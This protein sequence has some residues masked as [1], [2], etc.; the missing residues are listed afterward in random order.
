[1]KII[2]I[3]K[4]IIIIIIKKIKI[5]IMFIYQVSDLYELS[6]SHEDTSHHKAIEIK[7]AWNGSHWVAVCFEVL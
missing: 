5:I 3:V 1:M 4:M 2:I 6:C 7:N